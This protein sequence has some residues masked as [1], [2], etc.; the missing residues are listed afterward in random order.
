MSE[1][2]SARM[3]TRDFLDNIELWPQNEPILCLPT[4]SIEPLL[5]LST[6]KGNSQSSDAF[7][8]YIML[9]STV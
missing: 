7:N 9:L 4:C 3:Y 5:I 6:V 2:E 8:I 1:S